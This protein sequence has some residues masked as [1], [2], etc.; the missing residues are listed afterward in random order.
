MKSVLQNQLMHN[1]LFQNVKPEYFKLINANIF[2]SRKFIKDELILAKGDDSNFI[3]LITSGTV[4]IINYTEHNDRIELSQ[5]KVGDVI[6]E[7]SFILEGKRTA[8]VEC[9]DKVECL[10]ISKE[11]FFNLL[12]IPEISRNIMKAVADIVLKS[13]KTI[14]TEVLKNNTITELNLELEEKNILLE[15]SYKELKNNQNEIITLEQKNSILAM[16]VTANHEIN[17]PLTVVTGH[18]A[19]L[20]RKTQELNK[21]KDIDF[22]NEKILKIE[23][24]LNKINQILHKYSNMYDFEFSDYGSGIKMIKIRG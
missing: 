16:I 12:K 9:I 22:I 15:E 23:K 1:K 24:N 21:N 20:K 11:N 4:R 10:A 3:Y 6:G 18:L 13:D 7:L 19:L 5:K 14:V 2:E 17:Q 8:S